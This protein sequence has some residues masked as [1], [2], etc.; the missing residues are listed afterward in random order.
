MCNLAR[1][2]GVVLAG[3]AN[4][5]R[6]SGASGRLT[7]A[8]RLGEGAGMVACQFCGTKNR[9]DASFCNTCGGLLPGATP[10]AAA[11]PRAAPAT[12]P[13]HATGRLPPQSIIAGRY[14]ILKK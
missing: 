10:P 12:P 13:Q 5:T 1:A 7:G 11:A 6:A 2:R 14:L 8:R 4:G 3:T 9:A